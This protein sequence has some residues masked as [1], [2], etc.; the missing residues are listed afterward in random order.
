MVSKKQ[1]RVSWFFLY[2][3]AAGRWCISWLWAGGEWL[4]RWYLAWELGSWTGVWCCTP[5]SKLRKREGKYNSRNKRN[6]HGQDYKV[7]RHMNDDEIKQNGSDSGSNHR[8]MWRFH[9]D[10]GTYNSGQQNVLGFGACLWFFL[11][12][13]IAVWEIHKV[14]GY[15]CVPFSLT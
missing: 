4:L 5:H 3:G 7:T 10:H 6:A 1:W 11:K 9:I 14:E 12:K 2:H 15:S 13:I 8:G